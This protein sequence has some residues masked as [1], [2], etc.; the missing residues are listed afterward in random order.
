MLRKRAIWLA[1]ALSQISLAIAGGDIA[2]AT[3]PSAEMITDH[4]EVILTTE[5]GW[6]ELGWDTAAHQTGTAGEGLRIGSQT[7]AKGLGHHATGSIRLALDGD[8]ESFDAIIG[9]QPCGSSGSVIFRVLV[10]G[11]IAFDSGVVRA[12]N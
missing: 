12:T 4:P 11:A 1:A 2:T 6:G 8:Y 5:Q 3:S 7:F 9:L 10:D